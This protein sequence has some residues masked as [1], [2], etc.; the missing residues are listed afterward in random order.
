VG[1]KPKMAQ[2]R[3]YFLCAVSGLAWSGIAYLLLREWFPGL[4]VGIAAS[5]LI[6]L[7]VGLVHRPTYRF[8]VVARVLVA[9]VTL[10][11]AAAL[12]GLVL[13][14]VEEVIET[15]PNHVKGAAIIEWVLA[16]F[17]GLTFTGYFLFLWPLAFLN[18][19]LLGRTWQGEWTRK[20]TSLGA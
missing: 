14:V 19:W 1:T 13:G 3:Y 15:S 12:F 10:Y 16:T 6:G 11:A 9:L 8:P 17:W 18:H 7:L 2:A 20:R 5:P 4:W